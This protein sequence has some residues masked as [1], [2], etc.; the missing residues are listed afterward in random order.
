[1]SV[2]MAGQIQLLRPVTIMIFIFFFAF[3]V[4]T[5]NPLLSRTRQRSVITWTRFTLW[6]CPIERVVGHVIMLKKIEFKILEIL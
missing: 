3:A 4:P 6:I 2:K 5:A 1:M